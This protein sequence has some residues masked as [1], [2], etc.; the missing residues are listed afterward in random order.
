MKFETEGLEF[1]KKLTSL[2]QFTYSNSERS[3]CTIFETWNMFLEVS[4]ISYFRTII[5]QIGKKLGFRKVRKYY[6]SVLM[7][8]MNLFTYLLVEKMHNSWNFIVLT[9][10]GG[11]FTGYN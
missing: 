4:Q 5:I 2:E 1:A 8:P 3:V 9:F 7:T 10:F 6:F 11:F